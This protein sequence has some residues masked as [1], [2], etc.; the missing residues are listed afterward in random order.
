VLGGRDQVVGT[1]GPLKALNRLRADGLPVDVLTF[2]DATH[3]FDDDDANDPRT[4]YR[5]DLRAT[6]EGFYVK[7]LRS[8]LS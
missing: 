6:A 2:P 4:R 3:A 7:A 1:A 8:A 5:P